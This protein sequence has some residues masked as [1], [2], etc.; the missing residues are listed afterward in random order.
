VILQSTAQLSPRRHRL[1]LTYIE[2]EQLRKKNGE[3]PLCSNDISVH[4]PNFFS[5]KLLFLG[6]SRD[7]GYLSSQLDFCPAVASTCSRV[8]QQSGYVKI[9]VRI[10]YVLTILQFV[11]KRFFN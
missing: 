5:I 4:P 2:T 3:K 8:L 6:L 11:C 1:P 7:P 9:M 10:H